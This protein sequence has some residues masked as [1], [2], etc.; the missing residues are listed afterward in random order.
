MPSVPKQWNRA[1][2]FGEAP[3]VAHPREPL[4]VGQVVW[5][6]TAEQQ[7][8]QRQTGESTA[9][10]G[11][12]TVRRRGGMVVATRVDQESGEQ[13]LT[14]MD[15]RKRQG[16]FEVFTFQLDASLVDPHTVEPVSRHRIHRCVLQICRAL[17][18]N[19]SGFVDGWRRWLVEVMVGL[20]V[21]DDELIAGTAA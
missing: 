1:A 8:H 15:A 3:L 7:H 20:L 4:Q 12:P 14:V 2:W 19:Q 13:V 10:Q 21:V 18:E 6:Q 11:D 9:E 16:R 17:G 5:E